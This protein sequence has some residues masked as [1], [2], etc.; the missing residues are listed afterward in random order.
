MT[1]FINTSLVVAAQLTTPAENPL[2]TDD[3][4]LMDIWFG[5]TAVRKQMFK[6]VTRAEQDEMVEALK[7]R[8]FVQSGNLLLDPRAVLFAE[9]ENQFLGGVVTVGYG[10]NGKPVELKVGGKAFNELCCSL[11]QG[12]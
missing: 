12:N 5:G 9:M 2:L 1:R 8:G 3:S 10:E 6:K 7:G 11:N 4:R